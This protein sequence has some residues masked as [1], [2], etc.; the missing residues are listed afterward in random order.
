MPKNNKKKPV[1]V[2]KKDIFVSVVMV[3]Q[4]ETHNIT[5]SVLELSKLLEAHY[6][7]YEIIIVDNGAADKVIQALQDYLLKLP[8]IRVIRLAQIFKYD[9]ALFA[10]LEVSIGDYVCTLDPMVDPIKYIPQLI[11]ENKDNDVIQGVSELPI[12]ASATGQ[13][14]RRLFYWYNRKYINIDIPLNATYFASYSR[15]AIN[16]ITRTT[17]SQ[18]H[19]RH[20]ARRVGYAYKTFLYMPLRNPGSPKKLRAGIVEALEISI[21]YSTHPLRFVTRLGLLAGALNAIFALYVVYVNLIGT[22][23]AE[24]WTTTSL[25][26]SG[27][28]FILFIIVVIISEYIGRILMESYK[29]PNYYVTDELTSTVR[30]A[31]VNRRNV[32][33]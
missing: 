11:S 22:S 1:K 15:R 7:N 8:C 12:V 29:D 24:G 23:V 17:R 13:L 25:Q 4:A 10:G 30:L 5:E 9:T 20:L 6:T 33:K 32:E 16:S 28:F 31:D 27:M 26:L 18:Q 3:A 2:I 14:G 19:I 21:S